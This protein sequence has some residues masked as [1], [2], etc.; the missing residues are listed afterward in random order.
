MEIWIAIITG[1]AAAAVI[2][3]IDNVIMWK[4]GRKGKAEDKEA[5][6]R[7]AMEDKITACCEGLKVLLLDRIQCLGQEYMDKG[8]ASFDERRRLTSMHN[9]YHNQLGGNGDCDPIMETVEELP[10]PHG[11]HIK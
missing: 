2:K 1:G 4:L 3:I 5:E 7:K 11:T 8:E 10:F 9:V 6:E